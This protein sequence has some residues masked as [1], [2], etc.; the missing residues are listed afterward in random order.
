[1]ATNELANYSVRRYKKIILTI[2]I[3][4]MFSFIAY[5]VAMKYSTYTECFIENLRYYEKKYTSQF[6]F[7]SDSRT[8]KYLEVFY[9]NTKVEVAIYEIILS[10]KSYVEELC[11][12]GVRVKTYVYMTKDDY[13]GAIRNA[14]R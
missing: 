14:D 8:Q 2:M 9:N 5:K 12:K 4:A 11:I 13:L 10:D 6:L 7:F 1:M 3:C